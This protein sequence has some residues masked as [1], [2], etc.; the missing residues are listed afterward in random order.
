MVRR[1]NVV[2]LGGTKGMGRAL[3]RQLAERGDQLFLLG[4]DTRELE[5]SA[6]DLEARAPTG[7]RMEVGPPPVTSK[8]RRASTRP[9]TQ[10][11]RRWASWTA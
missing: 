5:R 2:I 11:R 7:A 6:R 4:R 9:S 1:M 8:S 3:S 10:P